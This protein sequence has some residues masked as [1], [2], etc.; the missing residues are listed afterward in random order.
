MNLLDI[1]STGE[2]YRIAGY[3]NKLH[4]EEFN[5]PGLIN[6]VD[7]QAQNAT[8]YD[9]VFNWA[10]MQ[11]VTISASV[12]KILGYEAVSF[13]SRGVNFSLGIVHPSDL[14]LLKEIHQA[15]FSYYYKTP[16]EQRAKLRFSY[17]IRLRAADE[18]YITI[19]R[20]SNFANFTADGKPT[21]EYFNCADI[22]G[23]RFNNAIN[24][25]I[26]KLSAAGTYV[27]CHETEF[28]ALNQTLSKREKEVLELARQGYT[29]K[30]I[31]A[32]LYLCIETV[33]SHR[34][35]IIAKTGGGNMVAA[36]NKIARL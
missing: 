5:V 8:G 17:N 16:A 34:K 2:L 12:K 3:S 11:Y 32:M 4:K 21:L 15:I 14:E 31:A 27:L 18:N 24:L 23:F 35:H 30:E 13:L 29:S 7:G 10:R 22:T 36:I 26:H 9:G 19:L 1:L 6:E 33:K 28:S 25:T 20:Q